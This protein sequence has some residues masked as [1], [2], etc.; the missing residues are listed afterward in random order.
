MSEPEIDALHNLMKQLG[1]LTYA[2]MANP[3]P[4]ANA[5]TQSL[6]N[7]TNLL[8]NHV[9]TSNAYYIVD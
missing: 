9:S 8:I 6:H 2:S 1:P 3:P 5:I 4:N 7:M